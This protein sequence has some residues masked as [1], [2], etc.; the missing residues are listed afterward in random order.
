MR[1][2]ENSMWQSGRLGFEV[3][4]FK[5][6]ESKASDIYVS[7]FVSCQICI[8]LLL[9]IDQNKENV[10]RLVLVSPGIDNV[11]GQRRCNHLSASY[12]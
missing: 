11:L 4:D 9:E 10:E 2:F 1:F 8:F 3:P 12:I 6:K 5:T 7:R